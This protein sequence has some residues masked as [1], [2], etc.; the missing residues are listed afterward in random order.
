MSK[1][2]SEMSNE[3]LWELFPIILSEHK[4]EW[5][6]E[7]QR[8]AQYLVEN[9]GKEN[10]IR[11]SHFGSTSVPGLLAKPTI[12]ILLEITELTENNSQAFIDKVISLG[13][14]YTYQ[15]SNPLPH[16]MFMKGYTPRG[17]EGQVFHLHVRY[18][19]DWDELYFCDYLRKHP[20]VA[21]EYGDLKLR[22]IKDFEHDRDGYTN[23]KTEF[24]SKY[25][26]LARKELNDC[27]R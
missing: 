25:T 20:E 13:Y 10:V 21:K 18:R 15:P 7:Y 23:A 11:I 8:E 17:F 16:M 9:I 4:S 5:F 1:E 14:N 22:L 12:D 2:L 3:E 24:I 6:D 19:G 26:L 27:F